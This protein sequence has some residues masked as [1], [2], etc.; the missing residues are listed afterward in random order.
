MRSILNTERAP[1]K[2]KKLAKHHKIRQTNKEEKKYCSK[3]FHFLI[4]FACFLNKLGLICEFNVNIIT[5]FSSYISN[6]FS[7]YFSIFQGNKQNWYIMVVCVNYLVF[8]TNQGSRIRRIM[9]LKRSKGTFFQT[10]STL[11]YY[12]IYFSF[13]LLF[14]L[15]IYYCLYT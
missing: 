9:P 2:L 14:Y 15:F 8:S 1:K 13:F 10:S 5:L 3:R 4:Q 11:R 12:F 7:F 6:V